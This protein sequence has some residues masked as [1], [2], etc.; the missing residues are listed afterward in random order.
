MTARR[1]GERNC[2][3]ARRWERGTGD[4]RNVLGHHAVVTEQF[5]VHGHG[6]HGAHRR[7]PVAA[8]HRKVEEAE[9]HHLDGDRG[10]APDAV[11]MGEHHYVDEHEECRG[12]ESEAVRAACGGLVVRHDPAHRREQCGKEEQGHITK[13]RQRSPSRHQQVVQDDQQCPREEHD[14]VKVAVQAAQWVQGLRVRVKDET[15][16]EANSD[17]EEDADDADNDVREAE[18][19]RAVQVGGWRADCRCR[20]SSNLCRQ[21]TGASGGKGASWKST[22]SRPRSSLTRRMSSDNRGDAI[23]AMRLAA[24]AAATMVQVTAREKLVT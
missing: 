6:R 21:G 16:D 1:T 19:A 23:S 14:E 24:V 5:Q 9:G 22:S 10:G 3:R 11:R 15:H 2:Q 12:C 8:Q 18:L 17:G 13:D 20:W 4:A 7:G